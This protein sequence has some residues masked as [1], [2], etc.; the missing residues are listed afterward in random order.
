MNRRQSVYPLG[1]SLFA[2]AISCTLRSYL[3]V[4]S[5]LTKDDEYEGYLIPEGTT[6][7]SRAASVSI[8]S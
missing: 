3:G 4:P 7:H 1:K 8:M 6:C 2:L 5:Q